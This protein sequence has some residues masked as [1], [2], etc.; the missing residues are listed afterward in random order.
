MVSHLVRKG[1]A[2]PFLFDTEAI[3]GGRHL[4]NTIETLKFENMNT[5]DLKNETHADA[6]PVLCAGYS[7]FYALEIQKRYNEIKDLY[8]KYRFISQCSG[9]KLIIKE[10]R[11]WFEFFGKQITTTDIYI[12]NSSHARM[13]HSACT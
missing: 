13:L 1:I 6:K 12:P 4:A 10:K 9:V 7:S 11:Y 2:A 5:D 8:S 3:T